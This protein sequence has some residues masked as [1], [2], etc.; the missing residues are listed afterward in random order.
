MS[1]TQQTTKPRLDRFTRNYLIALASI[2]LLAVAWWLSSIDYR[3]KALTK[4]LAEDATLASYPYPFKVLAVENG[5][6]QMSSPR[7]AQL[8]AIQALRV[9]Y[10]ELKN[11]SAVSAEMMAAQT[12]LASMQTHAAKLIKNQPDIQTIQW[13]LDRRWLENNGVTIE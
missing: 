4:V 3:A 7:S 13:L 12:E 5:V 1:S 8:S 10:P 11:K 9:I 6:A 2:A